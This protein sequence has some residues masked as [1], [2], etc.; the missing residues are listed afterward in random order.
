MTSQEIF[1]AVN[2]QKMVM[3]EQAR[4]LQEAKTGA[5]KQM[6]VTQAMMR[7]QIPMQPQPMGQMPRQTNPQGW[8]RTA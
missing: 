2:T 6:I 3:E 5:S 4:K 7:N 1:K 8:G